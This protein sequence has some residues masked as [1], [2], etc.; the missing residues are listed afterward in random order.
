MQRS[1]SSNATHASIPKLGVLLVA[2]VLM[3]SMSACDLFGSDD[4][5]EESGASLDGDLTFRAE[6]SS[7][8]SINYN[9]SYFYDGG[10][11]QSGGASGIGESLPV[12][13]ELNGPSSTDCAD[14][15]GDFDGVQVTAIMNN[16]NPDFLSMTLQLRSDGDVIDEATDS[17]NFGGAETWIVE[18][19]EV[20]DRSN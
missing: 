9:V 7:T 10:T 13:A 18:A 11:C 1:L 16:A 6:S 15:P 2:F 3:I 17:E 19:G 14:N 20:P 12:E 8:L 4:D 5:D